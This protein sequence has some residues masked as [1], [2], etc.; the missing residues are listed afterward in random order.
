[1]PTIVPVPDEFSNLQNPL[2]NTLQAVEQGEIIYQVNCASCHGVSGKG[3]G[4]VSNSLEPRPTNLAV[5]QERLSDG[6]LYWRIYA[7]GAFEPFRSVMPG[8]RGLI[9]EEDIWRVITYIRSLEG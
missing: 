1:M 5:N 3:D 9:S 2:E 6:Y 7:G 8:W 4:V